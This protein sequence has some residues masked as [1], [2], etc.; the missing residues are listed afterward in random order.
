MA[1]CL[2]CEPGPG[3]YSVSC[4]RKRPRLPRPR[5]LLHQHPWSVA[6]ETIEINR[7]FG[8]RGRK[9]RNT[10]G[11]HKKLVTFAGVEMRVRV[12][13]PTGILPGQC[14]DVMVED[15]EREAFS[16]VFLEVRLEEVVSPSEEIP[17][18]VKL[19]APQ[20]GEFTLLIL[21]AERT[22]E[23]CYRE[24]GS[25]TNDTDDELVVLGADG[26]IHNSR[27]EGEHGVGRE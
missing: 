9:E 4:K 2:V 7:T 3:P 15:F 23:S 8:Y 18:M 5:L 26:R 11:S 13:S 17:S 6:P 14:N 16:G 10:N 21:G 27:V 20:L 24:D 25:R 22:V 19:D 12:E 1:Y